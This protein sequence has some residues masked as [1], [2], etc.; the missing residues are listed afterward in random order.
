MNC[1]FNKGVTG[2][3]A[4]TLAIKQ[5]GHTILALPFRGLVDNKMA[6]NP[7][8]LGIHGKMEREAAIAE[9]LKS[10]DT[11]KIAATYDSIPVVCDTLLAHG[12]N[13]YKET[14]LFVDE[15][16][17]LFNHYRFR[18]SAVRMLLDRAQMFDRK[19]F[20]SATP[21]PREYWL[22]EL[23]DLPEYKIE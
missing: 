18:N 5:P 10:A 20:V 12:I 15:W 1:V 17:V 21:I 7:E 8:L 3:G 23:Q 9:Y 16:H 6:S 13:P 11:I 19:T 22:K 14:F 2:C 4:T